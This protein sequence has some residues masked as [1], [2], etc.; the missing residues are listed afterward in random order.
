[1]LAITAVV[2]YICT[3]FMCGL[4]HVDYI[5]FKLMPQISVVFGLTASVNSFF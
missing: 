1:M 4:L 2:F 5:Y 3:R